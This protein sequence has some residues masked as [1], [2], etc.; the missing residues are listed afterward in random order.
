MKSSEFTY[1]GSVAI[2]GIIVP[3]LRG[4]KQ[5]Q[6]MRD[7]TKYNRKSKYQREMKEW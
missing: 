4:Q 1:G 6:V 5:G 3:K 2:N 7:R